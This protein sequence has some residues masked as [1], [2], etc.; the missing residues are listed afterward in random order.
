MAEAKRSDGIEGPDHPDRRPEQSEE[1]RDAGDG[2]QDP[3]IVLEDGRL[4]ASSVLHDFLDL[5]T[6]LIVVEQGGQ[7]HSRHRGGV[8]FAQG[9]GLRDF[10]LAQ[11]LF[12]PLQNLI[13]EDPIAPQTEAALDDDAQG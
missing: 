7:E 5:V 2:P 9:S 4:V 8:A 13:L 10:T 3:Q 12:D 11:E 1:Y 6:R